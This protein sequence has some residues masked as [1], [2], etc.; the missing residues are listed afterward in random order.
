MKLNKVLL[1]LCAA[2]LFAACS[3]DDIMPNNQLVADGADGYITFG[4]HQPTVPSTRANDNFDDGLENEYE[5]KDATLILFGG[6]DE[7]TAT[8]QSAYDITSSYTDVND[9]PNQITVNTKITKKVTVPE[10]DKKFALVVLNNNGVIRVNGTGLM[11]NGVAFTGTLADLQQTVI[12][13]S[14]TDFHSNGFFMTNAPLADAVAPNE[15]AIKT[16][17]AIDNTK[18][19]PTANQSKED[20]NLAA[21]IFVERGVAKVTLEKDAAMSNETTEEATPH[22]FEILGWYLDNTNPQSYLVR[23]TNDTNAA[24]WWA[25]KNS[26]ATADEYRFTGSNVVKSG[27]TLYRTYFAEDPNYTGTAVKLNTTNE[28]ADGAWMTTF[29]LEHPAYCFENTFDVN[30]MIWSQTTRVVLKV[31]FNDGEDFY[32]LNGNTDTMYDKE[33]IEKMYKA[34]IIKNTVIQNAAKEK[35]IA[36]N[37]DVVKVTLTETAGKVTMSAAEVTDNANVFTDIFTQDIKDA[38][39]A[40]LNVTLYKGGIAYYQ[41]RVK[42]F[43]DDQTPWNMGEF[44]TSGNTYTAPTVATIYPNNDANAY[45]GRY[46]MLRNNWY[47]ITVKSIRTI[48]TAVVPNVDPTHDPNDP[49]DPT[50]PNTPDDELEQYMSVDI[51]VLSWAKRLQ[52]VDL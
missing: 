18:I 11:V 22:K 42:H 30:N 5:V 45:L 7:A 13:S 24:D 17:A 50:D 8:V 31:Q 51:N 36:L 3:S 33:N 38:I 41:V 23:N 25:L 39:N 19:F 16:L 28:I 12:E 26:A 14:T 32:I 47:D 37:E 49:N 52:S 4:V 21:E 2:G 15:G 43:G 35:N 6:V 20:G 48:G 1:G 29:D 10:G 40:A 46:G 44:N 27:V 9:D 34:Q